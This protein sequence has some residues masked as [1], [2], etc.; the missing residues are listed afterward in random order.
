MIFKSKWDKAGYCTFMSL[1]FLGV[2]LLLNTWLELTHL[3]PDYIAGALVGFNVAVIN[4]GT[5]IK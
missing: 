1:V 3:T 4:V 2:F 5:I